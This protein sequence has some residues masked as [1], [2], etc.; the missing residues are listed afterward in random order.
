MRRLRHVDRPPQVHVD[1]HPP[2]HSRAES[3]QSASTAL[4][5]ALRLSSKL[6][7]RPSGLLHL[8]Y[9]H[10][11]RDPNCRFASWRTR[12][13]ICV[14][15]VGSTRR[16]LLLSADPSRGRS[17][18]GGSTAQPSSP[19]TFRVSSR[20]RR[21]RPRRVRPGT[22]V[23]ASKAPPSQP[24]RRCGSLRFPCQ[25]RQQ[26]PGVPAP[27]SAGH[28]RAMHGARAVGTRHQALRVVWCVGIAKG[29]PFSGG[30]HRVLGM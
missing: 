12:V 25:A 19:M 11:H 10:L 1:S 22:A 9:V 13:E 7:A 21:P 29:P 3:C 30:L 26:T 24:A 17:R 14:S 4:T 27:A 23:P 20:P 6:P 28:G 16:H 8:P 2:G 5:L 18:A 15:D